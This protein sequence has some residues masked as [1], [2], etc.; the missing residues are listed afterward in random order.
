MMGTLHQMQLSIAMLR[1]QLRLPHDPLPAS[2][3]DAHALLVD[4]MRRAARQ[5][6]IRSRMTM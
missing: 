1:A 4:L 6:V 5:R 2:A 3:D